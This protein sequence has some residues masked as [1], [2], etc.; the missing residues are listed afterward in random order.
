MLFVVHCIR[1]IF[2]HVSKKRRDDDDAE[3]CSPK[4]DID[5][6]NFT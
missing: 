1:H 4:G 5:V 2:V 3:I 6:I